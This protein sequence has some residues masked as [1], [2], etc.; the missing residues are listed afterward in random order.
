[1]HEYYK[2]MKAQETKTYE[3]QARGFE[4]DDGPPPKKATP[5]E[6]FV[7]FLNIFY[8]LFSNWNLK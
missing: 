5:R 6:V 7:C 1:M 8:A 3:L 4:E 2:S